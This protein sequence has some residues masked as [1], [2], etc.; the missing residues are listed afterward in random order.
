MDARPK[1]AMPMASVIA[2]VQFKDWNA[3]NALI[4]TTDFQT[5]KK[6]VSLKMKYVVSMNEIFWINFYMQIVDVIEKVQPAWSAIRRM[7]NVIAKP[8]FMEDN[9]TNAKMDLNFIPI[10]QV[11]SFQP[12]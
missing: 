2:N 7:D 3:P 4:F 12:F 8:M 6:T 9:V 10:V 5:A 1:D 11:I